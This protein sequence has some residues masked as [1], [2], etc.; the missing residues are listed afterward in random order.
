MR[1]RGGREIGLD[2]VSLAETIGNARTLR[3]EE[4]ELSVPDGRSLATL[5]NVTP[6]RGKDGNEGRVG[7]GHPSGSRAAPG[8]A[9][10]RG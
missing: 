4:V 2:E 10:P 5:I 1:F 6:I 3:A 7:R 9:A 8:C